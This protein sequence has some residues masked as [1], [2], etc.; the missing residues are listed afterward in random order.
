MMYIWHEWRSHRSHLKSIKDERNAANKRIWKNLNEE[1]R[2]A[3]KNKDWQKA[4]YLKIEISNYK[5]EKRGH[6][7]GG[8]LP[9]DAR[10]SHHKWDDKDYSGV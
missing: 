6:Q 3:R 5:Y 1:L 8:L 2:V 7:W 9:F 4:N 10:H